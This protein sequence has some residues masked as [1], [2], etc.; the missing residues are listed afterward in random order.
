MPGHC[1]PDGTYRFHSGGE[2]VGGMCMLGTFS[3]RSVISE[4]SAI[5]VDPDCLRT[6]G[7]D[8][9][10]ALQG[11]DRLHVLCPVPAPESQRTAAAL[12]RAGG[13]IS[14]PVAGLADVAPALHRLLS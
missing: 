7:A 6:A 3:E 11:I 9:A 4:H 13:G 8:P 5:K 12:A 2:D 14:Q 10:A 1:L